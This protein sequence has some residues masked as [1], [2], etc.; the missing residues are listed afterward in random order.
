MSKGGFRIF[1]G[2]C[3]ADDIPD[4]PTPSRCVHRPPVHRSL[5]WLAAFPFSMCFSCNRFDAPWMLPSKVQRGGGRAFAGVSPGQR[6]RPL[7]CLCLPVVVLIHK[8]AA[9]RESSSS[10][11]SV[12]HQYP[13]I[14][15]KQASFFSFFSCA[16]SLSCW[17][18]FFL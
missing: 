2:A 3:P 11:S 6:L 7:A 12:T 4:M 17:S 9:R 14:E 15:N 10:S 8:F 16:S 5:G 13:E 1:E 18:S